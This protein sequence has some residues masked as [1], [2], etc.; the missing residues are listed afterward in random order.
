MSETVRFFLESRVPEL[1]DL[2]KKG[3]FS[4]EE[5]KKIVA[6]R[7]KFE[8]KIRRR[9]CLLDDFLAYIR[10]ETDLEA[11][12]K[13]RVA[14]LKIKGKHTVSDHSIVKSILSLYRKA[15]KKFRG[16]MPLWDQYIA[17][18]QEANVSKTM[19]KI[20]ASA[21]QMHPE[22][23]EIWVKSARWELD[24]LQNPSSARALFLR[25][26]RFNKT[27]L[28]L[29]LAY[30]EMELEVADKLA[31]KRLELADTFV[32]G[33]EE[34]LS[35][36]SGAIAISVFKYAVKECTLSA[37]DV[38]NFYQ[39]AV[40][41]SDRLEAVQT[42]IYD[43]VCQPEMLVD[44]Y[45]FF[46]AKAA[47]AIKGLSPTSPSAVA[48]IESC[49]RELN[50]A[51][52]SN[53][54]SLSSTL[55]SSVMN[56]LYVLMEAVKKDEE[57]VKLVSAKMNRIFQSAQENSCMTAELYLQWFNLNAQNTAKQSEILNSALQRFPESVELQK[58]ELSAT[59]STDFSQVKATILGKL[60]YKGS[61]FDAVLAE[62][63]ACDAASCNY[64][65]DMAYASIKYCRPVKECINYV[66]KH[67]SLEALLTLVDTS[68]LQ[69]PFLMVLITC[70]MDSNLIAKPSV[71]KFLSKV[72]IF[73]SSTF[74]NDVDLSLLLAK[75][76]LI[77]GDLEMLTRVS[78]QSAQL[79]AFNRKF[80][81]LKAS[82]Y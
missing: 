62:I 44:A 22:S 3:L 27:S 68:R 71:V 1:E 31:S 25:A 14:L 16:Y 76:S 61:Q 47:E 23:V 29:W 73:C 70:L 26:L 15:V 77:A 36:F 32:E 60:S 2:F 45:N 72:T 57:M 28:S 63:F 74:K 64:L 18:A 33:S 65:L 8:H 5:I 13:E 56:V 58:L 79:E 35:V 82:F 4:Q 75:A 12:R 54:D 9:G 34:G 50:V 24:Q 43:F 59:K 17:F 53:N 40:K 81:E 80:E 66:L 6:K 42:F 37:I 51:L 10:Y 20:F 46:V 41:Y 52:S 38:F 7:T 49:M 69:A 19:T 67:D 78:S 39:L 11:T 30:F 21:L 55:I 48:S